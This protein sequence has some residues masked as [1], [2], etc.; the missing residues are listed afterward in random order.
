MDIH[1]SIAVS[2]FNGKKMVIPIS[3]IEWFKEVE[4]SSY[5]KYTMIMLVKGLHLYLENG[6]LEPYQPIPEL[7]ILYLLETVDSLNFLLKLKPKEQK[8]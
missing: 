7:E 6:D 2:L 3:A 8:D 5:Q 1:N 4:P